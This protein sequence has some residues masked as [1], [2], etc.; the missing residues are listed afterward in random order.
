VSF[1]PSAPTEET[2]YRI[3]FVEALLS[4]PRLETSELEQL[5]L[6]EAMAHIERTGN[7]LNE[8][9]PWVSSPARKDRLRA[10]LGFWKA[11]GC[12]AFTLS[13]LAYG[14]KLSFIT[15]PENLSFPNHPSARN[16]SAFITDQVIDNLEDGS[17]F[18]ADRS[19][20]KVINPTQVEPKG[21]DKWR[22]CHDIRYPNSLTANAPFRLST[23]ARNLHTILQKNDQLVVSDLEKA[24]YSVPMHP[25]SWPYLC[26]DT[27]VGLM[28]GTCLLFGDAQSPFTFH[29]ITRHIV[30]ISGTLGIRVTSYLD[31]F[32]WMAIDQMR[33]TEP[34]P[35]RSGSFPC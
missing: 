7:K 25:S 21:K 1:C 19:F 6:K 2:E 14:K 35:S 31:D 22:Y 5:D 18:R 16:H 26:F 23:L 30:A 11:I 8:G 12:D 15:P 9:N 24:Y 32:L 27:P 33:S 34:T 3:P 29:K 17:F 4:S 13:W 28:A 10:R 20:A